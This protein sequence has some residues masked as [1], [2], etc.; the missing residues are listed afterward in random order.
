MIVAVRR[1]KSA[2]GFLTVSARH[3]LRTDLHLRSCF[4][5]VHRKRWHVTA[6]REARAREF[7]ARVAREVACGIAVRVCGDLTD[8]VSVGSAGPV[9]VFC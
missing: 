3:G 2:N 9:R 1:E 6:R 4:E 5:S 8:R 7:Y